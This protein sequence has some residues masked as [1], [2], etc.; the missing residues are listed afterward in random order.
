MT[1]RVLGMNRFGDSL[2]GSQIGDGFSRGRSISQGP[3][4]SK[5][6]GKVSREEAKG[7]RGKVPRALLEG[8]GYLVSQGSLFFPF[9]VVFSITF[10]AHER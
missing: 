8:V 1:F 7:P 2:K 6:Q 3:C 10:L 9:L 5:Q 4:L